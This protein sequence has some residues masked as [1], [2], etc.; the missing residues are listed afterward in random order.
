MSQGPTIR[1]VAAVIERDGTYLITQRRPTAVLPL[2][3]EFPGGRVE[4][5]E[6]DTA[7]LQREVRH[8]LGVE[9]A[10]VAC[11]TDGHSLGAGNL[12]G[13]EP[14]CVNLLDHRGDLR[15]GRLRS[16]DDQHGDLLAGILPRSRRPTGVGLDYSLQRTQRPPSRFESGVGFCS[17][18]MPCPSDLCVLGALCGEPASSELQSRDQAGI[19]AHGVVAAVPNSLGPSDPARRTVIR[20]RRDLHIQRRPGDHGEVAEELP[21]GL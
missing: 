7:A 13:I 9:R 16:H 8:R 11:D 19:H 14:E 21:A 20:I 15:L 1:V 18:R 17:V 6:T 10:A 2:M 4:E 5:D 12:V 3:W